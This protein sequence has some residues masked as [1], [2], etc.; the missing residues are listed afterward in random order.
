MSDNNRSRGELVGN[1]VRIRKRGTMWYAS[2]HFDGQ[3]QRQSLRTRSK[4][5]ARRRAL[6]LEA[7]L[8]EGRHQPEH[9]IPSISEVAESYLA[10]SQTEGR[11]QKTVTKYAAVFR[12]VIALAHRT[13][14]TK[15]SK[16]DISFVDRYRHERVAAGIAAKTLYNET[17]IIRQMVNFALSRGM[18]R[19]DP[20]Q[21]I[22]IRE[23]KPTP[24]PCWTPAEVEHI[25][26]AASGPYHSALVLLAD[27]GMRVGELQHLAWDDIKIYGFS[28]MT[29]QDYSATGANAIKDLT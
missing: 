26:V 7:D 24:Q 29:N 23:P 22:R 15:I 20:L 4:K 9:K 25:L 8:T 3:Q 11:T 1:F 21:G 5:E 19:E 27:T 28:R 2:F 6:R 12:R 16:L 14:R 10:N 17:T 18:I 13:R